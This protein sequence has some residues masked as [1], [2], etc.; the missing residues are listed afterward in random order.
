MHRCWIVRFRYVSQLDLCDSSDVETNHFVFSVI[1]IRY[2]QDSIHVVSGGLDNTLKFYDLNAATDTIIGTHTDAI[3]CVEMSTKVNGILTGSWDKTI[4]LWDTREKVCV[5]TYEQNNGKVYSMDVVD[6]KVVVATSD[7]K[8]LVWDLRNMKQYVMRRE[9]SLK[10]QTRCIRVFPN[11]DGYVM[12]S[13]EGRV[14]V[15]YFDSDPEIQKRKFAF[16]CHRTK[17]N[18]MEI[19]HPVNAI[20]F[21]SLY[22]TFATG[23][24]DSLVMVLC[25]LF[26]FA[27]RSTSVECTIL[28]SCR[29]LISLVYRAF[30]VFFSFI[31][32]YLAF[33][34]TQS[35]NFNRIFYADREQYRFS[36]LDV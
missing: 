22:N 9:S 33:T 17:D 21:H 1:L 25:F 6:E 23:E 10:Y 32:F 27:I 30:V 5:G 15:E 34:F 11:K 26:C 35:I 8:V 7:R 2:R 16:K 31:F 20:S 24:C 28:R 18:S 12:S 29:R 19:I 13:I 14:A 4:K 3:K 36:F